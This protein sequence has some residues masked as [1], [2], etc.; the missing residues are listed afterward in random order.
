MG[1]WV[2]FTPRGFKQLVLVESAKVKVVRLSQESLGRRG[3]PV[4]PRAPF[5]P[6]KPPSVAK[7]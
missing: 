4:S 6:C 1:M 3:L 7:R 2:D 5:F